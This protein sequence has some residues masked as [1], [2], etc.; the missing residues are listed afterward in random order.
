M[1]GQEMRA[2]SVGW[3][4]SDLPLH[5]LRTQGYWRPYRGIY[6]PQW[7]A[8]DLQTRCEALRAVLPPQSRFSHATAASL[9]G[10]PV[11]ASVDEIH[12]TVPRG[13]V[14]PRRRPGVVT[15]QR[16]MDEPPAVVQG[17]PVSCPGQ[18]LLDLAPS[19]DLVELVVL[20]D[21]LLAMGVDAQSLHSYLAARAGTRGIVRARDAVQLVRVGVDSPPETRLR[22]IIVWAGLPEPAV[23]VRVFDAAGG[24]IGSPDLG[25]DEFQIAV[26]YEGDVHRTSRRRWRMDV[27]RDEAYTDAGW[28]VVRA[29]ADDVVRP[30]RFLRRLT[31]R[32]LDR[33]WRP[34]PAA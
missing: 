19:L 18:L 28:L 17:L 7:A 23:N 27:A 25:Y 1:S 8:D 5:R 26:Q 15:H 32:L 16:V 29:T 4:P 34:P 14:T 3:T 10:L 13:V 30:H 20:G 6:L 9:L 2:P 21:A 11:T 12:V 22:L 31:R 33:G 24:W